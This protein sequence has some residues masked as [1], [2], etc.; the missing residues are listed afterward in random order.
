MIE[1]IKTFGNKQ[2]GDKTDIESVLAHRLV[3][4]RK[5]AKYYVKELSPEAMGV[6]VT[7]EPTVEEPQE[8]TPQE[9]QEQTPQ[10]KKLAKYIE[11]QNKKKPNKK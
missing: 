10:E 11:K 3:N 8:Q 9:P 7:T 5:V 4:I 1:F 2:V 6:R